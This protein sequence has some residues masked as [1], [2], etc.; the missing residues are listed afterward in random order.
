MYVCMYVCVI[1]PN[2]YYMFAYIHSMYC[3]CTYYVLCVCVHL[4]VGCFFKGIK[5]NLL[6]I[7]ALL[8]FSS[9]STCND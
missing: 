2:T 1:Y 4:G 9:Q 3:V 5:Q 8:V 6:K 7:I